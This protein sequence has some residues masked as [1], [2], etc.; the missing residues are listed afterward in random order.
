MT[1]RAE[2]TTRGAR[3]SDVEGLS[4][5]SLNSRQIGVSDV[6]GSAS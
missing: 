2:M 6:D 5:M 3:F 4:Q 1:E